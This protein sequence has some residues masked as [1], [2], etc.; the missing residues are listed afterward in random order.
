MAQLEEREADLAGRLAASDTDL[1]AALD[2]LRESR[3]EVEE[4][5]DYIERKLARR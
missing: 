5:R 4:L 3:A 1:Q 2:A